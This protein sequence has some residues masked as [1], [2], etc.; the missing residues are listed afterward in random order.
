MSL[1]KCIVI[2]FDWPINF[3]NPAMDF[4]LK[5][6]MQYRDVFKIVS[7]IYDGAFLLKMRKAFGR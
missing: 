7:T 4:F 5:L 1:R 3:F 6:H 2:D